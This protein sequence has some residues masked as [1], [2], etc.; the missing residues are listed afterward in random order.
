M[1]KSME[2]ACWKGWD[3]PSI[4]PGKETY[5]DWKGI[6]GFGLAGNSSYFP[7][8]TEQWQEL[9]GEKQKELT[10]DDDSK[11]VHCL[12]DDQVC[13]VDGSSKSVSVHSPVH[14]TVRRRAS[15]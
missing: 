8:M 10:K 9:V 15:S 7:H 11:V 2:T 4:V 13:F 5:D 12:R 3:D 14:E 6:K 1:G